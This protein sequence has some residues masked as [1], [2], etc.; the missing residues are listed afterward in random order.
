MLQR[1]VVTRQELNP[2]LGKWLDK[3]QLNIIPTAAPIGIGWWTRLTTRWAI[4]RML[5]TILFF[6][7][8][9]FFARIFV[10][11]FLVADP[12]VGFLNHPMIELP[13]F[14]LIPPHLHQ[15]RNQ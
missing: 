4:H 14:D 2:I 13:C 5:F 10:S 8:L 11:Y 6:V 7:W 3:L 9:V 15:G 1:G 12:I